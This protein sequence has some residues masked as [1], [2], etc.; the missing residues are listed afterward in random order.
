LT[1]SEEYATFRADIVNILIFKNLT[2]STDEGNTAEGI[3]LGIFDCG[4]HTQRNLH[5]VLTG[6]CW[7]I[8]F[9]DTHNLRGR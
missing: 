8:I 7:Y 9:A 4:R 2:Y 1:I 5:L 3:F 6:R